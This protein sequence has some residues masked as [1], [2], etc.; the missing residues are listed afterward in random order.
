MLLRRCDKTN[1]LGN[2]RI[3]RELVFVE[4]DSQDI[5][6]LLQ[7]LELR[8]LFA[9][10]VDIKARRLEE[11]RITEVEP[12][13]FN[14]DAYDVARSYERIKDYL[15]WAAVLNDARANIGERIRI[16]RTVCHDETTGSLAGMQEVA[17]HLIVLAADAASK[18]FEI[19]RDKTKIQIDAGLAQSIGVFGTIRNDFEHPNDRRGLSGN[20]GKRIFKKTTTE[21]GTTQAFNWNHAFGDLVA[22]RKGFVP[23]SDQGIAVHRKRVG[24]GLEALRG[25]CIESLVALGEISPQDEDAIRWLLTRS[26]TTSA[27][28]SQE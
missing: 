28:V 23:I 2:G 5:R 1:S 15:C 12:P 8:I 14:D 19:V 11:M 22:S 18:Y 24:E 4:G 13:G 16:K 21:D 17:L 7:S 26:I 10:Y 3:V 9:Q 27:G 20:Y 6:S 25:R